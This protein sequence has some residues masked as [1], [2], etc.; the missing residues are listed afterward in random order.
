MRRGAGVGPSFP[1]LNYGDLTAAQVV[2]RLPDLKPA[3]LRKVRDHERRGGSRKSV[4]ARSR[5]GWASRRV[6]DD[7]GE[8]LRVDVAARERHADAAPRDVD[9]AREHRRQGA[10]PAGLHHE[11]AALEQ[12]AHRPGDLGVAHRDDLLDERLEDR[13]RELARRRDLL[14]VGDRPA[15][16]DAHAVAR[17]PASGGCRR[18][19]RAPRRRRGSTGAAPSPPR[20]ARGQ[21]APARAHDQ[22]V[23]VVRRPR[24]APARWCPAPR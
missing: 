3:E 9:A 12:H 14:A 7:R 6:R 16:V 21:A 18:P 24:R 23:E 13:E 20:A 11:L 4:L 8:A 17:R 1:I 19:P 2:A 5:S 15:H 10:R 22:H